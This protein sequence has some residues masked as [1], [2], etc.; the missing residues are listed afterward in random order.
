MKKIIKE[1]IAI[2]NNS[3]CVIKLF[4][5]NETVKLIN[6]SNILLNYN[7]TDIDE[8]QML[9]YFEID[10]EI[11]IKYEKENDKIIISNERER[12]WKKMEW[13]RI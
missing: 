1:N 5:N 4:N 7:S 2:K 6:N 9:K 10:E 8:L 3:L 11:P 13:K 12:K